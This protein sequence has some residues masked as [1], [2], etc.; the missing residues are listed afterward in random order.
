MTENMPQYQKIPCAEKGV[1]MIE[2]NVTDLSGFGGMLENWL[3]TQ[4]K[5]APSG[6]VVAQVAEAVRTVSQAQMAY[7]QTVMRANAALLATVWE[8]F[9]VSASSKAPSSEEAD[10]AAQ[11]PSGVAS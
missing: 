9:T 11:R 3:A 6:Q 4:R 2:K 8:A 5:F 7:N 1:I 10:K